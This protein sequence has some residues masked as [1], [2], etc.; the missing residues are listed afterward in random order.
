MGINF[1][2]A[3][4]E[5][6]GYFWTKDQY[7]DC[8]G[9]RKGNGVTIGISLLGHNLCDFRANIAVVEGEDPSEHLWRFQD[10]RWTIVTASHGAWATRANTSDLIAELKKKLALL[11]HL[12]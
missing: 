9:L 11:K 12:S 4:R 10:S 5:L 1:R 8:L 3:K 6:P 7:G 2:T